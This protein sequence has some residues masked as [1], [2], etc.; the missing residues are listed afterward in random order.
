MTELIASSRSRSGKKIT[1]TIVQAVTELIFLA[2]FYVTIGIYL[3]PP[4]AIVGWLVGLIIAYTLP[5]LFLKEG[6]QYKNYTKVAFVLI[7]SCVL[8]ALFY[9]SVSNEQTIISAIVCLV[10]NGFFIYSGIRNYLYSWRASFT[11]VHMLISI[12]AF[13]VLQILKI[14]LLTDVVQYNGIFNSCGMMVII[15]SL[16][17][18][19]ERMLGDQQIVNES[20]RTSRM[21]VRINRVLITII[22]VVLL[23]FAL[24][25]SIQKQIEDWLL[26]LIRR[27]IAWFSSFEV[28]EVV[29]ERTSP[30][31]IGAGE[32]LPPPKEP[33]LFWTYLELI[34]KYL[35]FAV[36]TIA[37]LFLIIYGSKKIFNVIKK[38]IG[39]LF[40]PYKLGAGSEDGYIDEIEVLQPIGKRARLPKRVKHKTS[41][42]DAKRWSTLSNEDKARGLYTHVVKENIT[43]GFQYQAS[44]TA[45]QTIEEMQVQPQ[46]QSDTVRS[47]AS[48]DQSK[49]DSHY[50]QLIDVYNE[51]RYG[52]KAPNETILQKLYDKFI[53]KK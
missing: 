12:I 33:S 10:A 47:A 14:T 36:I 49:T 5:Q 44:Y 18:N 39:K 43:T 42:M 53:V 24:L 26:N 35:V 1:R 19:N 30:P 37:A 4:I 23:A 25:R 32:A 40:N 48:N 22:S 8:T 7:S 16:Y 34:L 6:K 52:E 45:K 21:S 13:I 38:L 2:P 11:A 3:F 15:I 50:D 46:A 31:V 41:Y 28:A 29:E 17:I 9:S 27:I 20:S 51:A